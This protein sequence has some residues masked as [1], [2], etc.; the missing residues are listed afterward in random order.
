MTEFVVL[1]G[2]YARGDF[3]E[4]SDCDIF[5]VGCDKLDF[6][7]SILPVSDN[8][9]VSY[10]DYDKDT[11]SRL[12]EAGSL[13][14]YHVLNEGQLIY[15][16]TNTWKKLRDGFSVQQDFRDELDEILLVTEFLSNTDMFGG[17]FLTPL[18]NAFTELKNA[19]I[20]FLA[21]QGKYV[22]E[23]SECIKLAIK[24]SAML[25]TLLSLKTFYDY[26][27]RG[28]DLELPFD[29][30]SDENCREVLLEV[31]RLTLG[32]RNACQ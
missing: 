32:L 28:L 4:R 31:H 13:F 10:I 22:F 9:V 16:D 7:F 1:I 27:V 21:H 8:S 11:F 20:F 24:D 14:L 2:S 29:A 15:G 5:R 30:N 26:S 23:K 25:P 3:N 19:S 6:D 18:V 17:K 12:Y